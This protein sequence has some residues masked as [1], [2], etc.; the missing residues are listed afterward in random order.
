[1]LSVVNDIIN[2]I[3]LDDV[4]KDSPVKPDD[5]RNLVKEIIFVISGYDLK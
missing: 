2:V 3:P 1:M 4:L 5:A